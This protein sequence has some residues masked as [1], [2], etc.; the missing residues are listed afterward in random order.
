M[1]NK[2]FAIICSFIALIIFSFII[3]EVNLFISYKEK[4]NYYYLAK[5]MNKENLAPELELKQENV[6]E[7]DTESVI[8]PQKTEKML[9]LEDLHSQNEDI[10][11]WIEIP[12]N[13]Y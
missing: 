6:I 9:K 11:A 1:K 13:I 2:K 10:V 5:Y 4:L 7:S 12:R 3:L 8:P